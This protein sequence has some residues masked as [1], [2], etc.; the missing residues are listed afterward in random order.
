MQ[1]GES[2]EQ[3]RLGIFCATVELQGFILSLFLIGEKY[4]HLYVVY[5]LEE[6]TYSHDIL[7]DLYAVAIL[8]DDKVIL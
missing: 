3:N 2:A 4:K 6:H 5:P 7:L 8:V 1:H